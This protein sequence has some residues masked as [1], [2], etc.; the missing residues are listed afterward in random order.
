MQWPIV[1]GIYADDSPDFRIAYPINMVPVPNGTGISNGYLRPADGL[2][3]LVNGVGQDR[4]GINWN[5]LHYRVQGSSLVS[6]SS[7]NTVSVLG[8]VGSGKQVTFDYSFDRLAI[9]SGG[10][11]YYW[12]GATLQQV[13]DPDLGTVIDLIWIDGYF[14][15]TDGEFLIVTD[16]DNPLS[17]NPLKYG[18]SEANPDPIKGLLKVRNEAYA[19][20]RYTIEVFDNVGGSG[21]PFQRIEG[22]QVQK[23]VVGTDA[24]CVFLEAIAFVGSGR[25]E[26]NG[27]Y[28]AQNGA[29]QKI[30]TREIDELLASYLEFQLESILVESRVDKG[31]QQLMVH[32][33]DRCMVYDHAASQAF[34]QPVWFCLTSSIGGYSQYRARNLVWCYGRWN[35]ADSN[36]FQIG[37]LDNS[38]ATQFGDD[39][40]WEF[41]TRAVY[42]EGRGAIV[43]ELELVALNGYSAVG[44]NPFISTCY[45]ID[46]RN[47][48]QEKPISLGGNGDTRKRLTWLQQGFL[49]NWRIQKFKGDSQSMAAFLRLQARVEGLQ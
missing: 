45:S 17:V 23:G 46:G 11:M 5:G 9:A 47:W 8:D 6:I 13:V 44:Q 37:Y 18:S 31:T 26:A 21:F 30:S 3:A 34:Q 41:S 22:A 49:R 1:Q 48:S 20:N 7:S 29:A 16:L 19:L 12:D 40:R 10:R 38:I 25:N 43:H 4:G 24:A 32:L 33:P 36:T 39:V 15:T 27:V 35:C 14:M 2:R 42:N 28:I